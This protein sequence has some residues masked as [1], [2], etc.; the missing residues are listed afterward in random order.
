MNGELTDYKEAERVPGDLVGLLEGIED[1][2]RGAASKWP[3]KYSHGTLLKVRGGAPWR[4]I[5]G[6]ATPLDSK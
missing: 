1:M 5:V 6:V 4:V 3:D 2:V